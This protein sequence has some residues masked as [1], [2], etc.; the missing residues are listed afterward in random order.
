[1]E[2]CVCFLHLT[3]STVGH[4]VEDVPGLG[5]DVEADVHL[6]PGQVDDEVRVVLHWRRGTELVTHSAHIT[7][8]LGDF[9]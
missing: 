2:R 7:L 3:C 1:M 9:S 4:Q 6:V 8:Q 5:V